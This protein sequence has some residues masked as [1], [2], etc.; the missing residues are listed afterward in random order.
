MAGLALG[1]YDFGGGESLAAP[2]YNFSL[3]TKLKE[4]TKINHDKHTDKS[5]MFCG[6]F[7]FPRFF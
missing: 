5:F 4:F 7:S 6:F 3:N 1:S 2:K